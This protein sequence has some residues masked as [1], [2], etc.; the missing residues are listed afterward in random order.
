MRR[1]AKT[2][3]KKVRL[4]VPARRLALKL[5]LVEKSRPDDSEIVEAYFAKESVRKLHIGCGQYVLADWLNSDF[6]P[7]SPAVIHLD[8]TRPFPFANDTFDFIFTEHMIEH[9]SYANGLA[10]LNECRRVLKEN[11]TI[12]ISTPDLR[13][14]IDLYQDG[15]S[16][17][18]RRYIE[19][20]T[21]RFDEKVPFNDAVFVINNFV[22]AWGHLFIYDEKVLRSSLEQ[23]GFTSIRKCEVGKSQ[24]RELRHLENEKRIPER[25]LKL[26]SV[27]LEGTK[28]IHRDSRSAFET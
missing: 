18:K 15:K 1:L 14:L 17:I 24:I 9:V 27:I 8:A 21:G 23:S 16:D 6:Y 12:R 13:F 22:R 20:S 2:L 3:L 25:F 10:M 28:A 5:K 7:Q 26:E 19:W 4:Y 11:G